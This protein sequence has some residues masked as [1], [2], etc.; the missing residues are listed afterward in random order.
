MIIPPT[1]FVLHCPKLNPER[2]I[3]LEKHLEERVPIKDVRWC[4][5]Y[6][7][8]HLF[9]EW[10][11]HT[12]KLPYGTKIT[13]GLVKYLDICKTMI[14]E[15]IP[16]AII[17]ND[18]AIF[19]R[20]WVEVY[21]SVE[22][23]DKVLFINL[24]TCL[25]FENLK[26][27]KCKVYSLTNNGGCEG[28]YVSKQFAKLFLENLN[29][30]YTIDIM[31]HGF[32]HWVKHPLLGLPICY[33]TSLME[34]TSS[35]DHD[36]R[37]DGTDWQKFVTGYPTSPKVNYFELLKNFD[38]YLKIK[39]S[40]EEQIFDLYGKKVNLRNIDYILGMGEFRNTI[41]T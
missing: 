15:D 31:F 11:H 5:D 8:D 9:V 27:E 2:K 28:V 40:K 38:D 3:F 10:L 33:Q 25:M 36:T 18:D 6:N 21:N 26:P 22:L 13:S 19:H 41:I 16:N 39:K 4:E 29:M 1:V 12:Q 34:K 23:S 20:D 30:N 37:T 32:L 7:H 14:D 17:L 35:L 24:G